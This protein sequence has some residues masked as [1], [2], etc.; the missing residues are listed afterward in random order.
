MEE[1]LE[2]EAVHTMMETI[3]NQLRVDRDRINRAL[4]ILGESAPKRRG[5]PPGTKNKPKIVERIGPVAQIAK[6]RKAA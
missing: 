4:D 3:V 6:K 1:F 2:K 5:R